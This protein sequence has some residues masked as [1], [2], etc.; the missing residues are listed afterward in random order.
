M[1][2]ACAAYVST[3]THVHYCSALY[4]YSVRLRDQLGLACKP[5]GYGGTPLIMSISLR[6]ARK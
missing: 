2:E 3:C 6:A 1:K 4:T 5:V